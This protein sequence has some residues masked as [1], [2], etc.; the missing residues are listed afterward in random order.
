MW[1]L[2]MALDAFDVGD[3]VTIDGLK[4]ANKHNG[5]KGIIV[6]YVEQQGRYMIKMHDDQRSVLGVRPENMN[7]PVLQLDVNRMNIEGGGTLVGG[8]YVPS[9]ESISLVSLEWLEPAYPAISLDEGS[10]SATCP[11]CRAAEPPMAAYSDA[12]TET[13]HECPVCLETKQC[14]LLQC[15]HFVC[16]DCWTSWRSV[17]CGGPF[18]PAMFDPE[19]LQE[20]RAERLREVLK[21][22]P[23]ERGGTATKPGDSDEV[24]A[25]VQKT[26]VMV[27]RMK[28]R[29]LVEDAHNGEQGL[30]RF[31]EE[32]MVFPTPFFCDPALFDY[33][34]R[35]LD[36]PALVIVVQVFEQRKDECFAHLSNLSLTTFDSSVEF[37]EGRCCVYC[38]KIG[39]KYEEVKNYRGSISW[40][41][42]SVAHAIK[43]FKVAPTANFKRKL[44]ALH[45]I[46][47]LA[48][49]KAGSLS[50]AL[51]NYN[52]SLQL[53]PGASA[54]P[55]HRKTL[56]LEMKEW[57]G[58]SGKLT[59]GC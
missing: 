13:E 6:K 17:A 2:V 44:S 18:R 30:G 41:E 55:Q 1:S 47:G 50:A 54:L 28:V 10:L 16:S 46:L 38:K 35:V 20:S 52:A 33:F 9:Y 36:I 39:D 7:D 25:K 3:V 57:T 29:S 23:H 24:R 45:C 31:W 37:F 26:W 11:K 49:K 19:Q 48:Q 40:Y 51:E 34:V 43:K 42:R 4:V 27:F 22:L 58:S 8:T 59:P 14:R 15:K 32:L 53:E 5:K 21:I 56:L 12:P